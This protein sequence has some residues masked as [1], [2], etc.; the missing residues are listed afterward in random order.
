MMETQSSNKQLQAL[1]RQELAREP[2]INSDAVG[3]TADHGLIYLSG[4]ALGVTRR[5]KAEEAAL[6]V[7]GV[8]AVIDELKVRSGRWV[9]H[10]ADL[11]CVATDCLDQLIGLPDGR[12]K[13]IVGDGKVRLKGV[14]SSP[15]EKALIASTVQRAIGCNGAID[16]AIEVEPGAYPRMALACDATM[17]PRDGK[18]V[19]MPASGG[20]E[21]EDSL[22]AAT[23]MIV[24]KESF[25][26]E[27]IP[28]WHVHH[29]E[30]PEIR[31]EG[32]TSLQ[33]IGRL[34]QLLDQAREH[35]REDWQRQSIDQAIRDVRTYHS[36]LK[37]QS[38]G[39]T[40]MAD[41]DDAAASRFPSLAGVEA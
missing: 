20:S 2:S 31:G 11:A 12:V 40:A 4:H 8:R 25:T 30:F 33:G 6:R 9:N 36:S 5:R 23:A 22:P 13:V 26:D 19:S 35:A 14:V 41:P 18:R 24:V 10:D 34:V 3:I 15:D 27:G 21:F 29:C 37:T 38:I 17:I 1:V 39:E 16:N 28:M 32:E 7:D